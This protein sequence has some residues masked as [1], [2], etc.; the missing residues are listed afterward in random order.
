MARPGRRTALVTTAVVTAAGLLLTGC[1]GGATASD[2]A[3]ELTVEGAYV[4]APPTK[5]LAAGYFVVTNS[6]GADAL[7]SVT[8]DLADEVTLHST[9][10]GRMRERRSLEVPADGR[11]ELAR[12]GNHLMFEGLTR[13]PVRGDTVTLRLRFEKAGV[14]TVKAP[15]REA[16]YNPAHTGSSS[17]SSAAD[18]H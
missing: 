5:S 3:P 12:G 1:G 16:T 18:H 14:V 7:T 17:P 13:K 2:G 9:K 6:G 10:D 11:L 8:S 4:P 15:V